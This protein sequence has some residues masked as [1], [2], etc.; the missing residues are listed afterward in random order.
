MLFTSAPATGDHDNFRRSADEDGVLIC[1]FSGGGS[2]PASPDD[3]N[4]MI[5]M[6][7]LHLCTCYCGHNVK[8]I[9]QRYGVKPYKYTVPVEK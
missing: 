1:R 3:L 8:C 7:T 9:H 5:T 4:L 6:T 2:G